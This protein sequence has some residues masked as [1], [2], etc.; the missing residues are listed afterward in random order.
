MDTPECDTSND[1]ILFPGYPSKCVNCR[2]LKYALAAN[3][4]SSCT[5][6]AGFK[7]SSQ[8]RCV[9]DTNYY[10]D[11]RTKQCLPC[12]SLPSE[13]TAD[14][15]SCANTFDS[16]RYGCALISSYPNVDS[17]GKCPSPL[18]SFPMSMRCGCGASNYIAADG[19]CTSCPSFPCIMCSSTYFPTY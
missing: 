2:V 8:G 10:I 3:S 17:S 4:S 11:A 1:Y 13:L 18:R 7:F 6:R 14:C 5:C 19:S 16:G 12:S 15:N 9:C